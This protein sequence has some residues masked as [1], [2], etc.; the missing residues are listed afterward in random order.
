MA[1]AV[2]HPTPGDNRLDAAL[3]KSAAMRVGNVFSTLATKGGT[4]ACQKAE[5]AVELADKY[6]NANLARPFTLDASD[7][8]YQ[9]AH[10]GAI[11][12]HTG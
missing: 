12:P 11:T 9:W 3:S 1:A 7:F 10:R 8:L 6:V 4:L 5:P 2:F